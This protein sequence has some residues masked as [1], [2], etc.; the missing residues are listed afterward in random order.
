MPTSK[1]SVD[2][3]PDVLIELCAKVV[4]LRL[5]AKHGLDAEDAYR[6]GAECAEE[7]RT[8]FGG[9][10]VYIPRMDPTRNVERDREIFKRF[11][12]RN[13]GEL[14]LEYGLTK[15]RVRQIIAAQR[16]RRER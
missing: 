6:I 8:A 5:T 4:A 10:A 9:G 16:V 12:G 3:R 7:V 15:E 2:D 14:G 11:N 13:T 1:Y